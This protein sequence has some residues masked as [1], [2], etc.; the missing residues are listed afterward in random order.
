MT[1][2]HEVTSTA[3]PAESRAARMRQPL[4]ADVIRATAEK[5]G[6]CVR[7]FTMEVGDTETGELRYVAGAV[8]LHGGIGLPA[9]CAEGEGVAAGPVPRGL[10]PGR[11][12]RL[13][14]GAAD[15]GSDGAA[16]PTAPTWS[17][18]TGDV[19]ERRTRRRREELR[20]EIHAVDDGTSAT[21]DARPSAR[22]RR[23]RRS[24]R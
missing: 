18:P 1:T 4:A 15:R 8:R 14:P 17:R 7:P 12:T 24:G 13:H 2:T 21:R 20:D 6:V 9:V 19:V 11:R 10:A 22:P 3:Q 23:A 5:H 16:G